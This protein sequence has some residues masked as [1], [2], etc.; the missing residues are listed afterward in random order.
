M[1]KQSQFPTDWSL[2]LKEILSEPLEEKTLRAYGKIIQQFA[3]FLDT[4]YFCI[5]QLNNTTKEDIEQFMNMMINPKKSKS[6]MSKAE[7]TTPSPA[8]QALRLSTLNKFYCIA[9]INGLLDA[10]PVNI[11]NVH[12]RM[13]G[14]CKAPPKYLSKPLTVNELKRIHA[15]VA[16]LYQTA[17]SNA[18]ALIARDTAI[19]YLLEAS[20]IT[21]GELVQLDIEMLDITYNPT[22]FIRT[23]SNPRTITLKPISISQQQLRHIILEWLNQRKSL[24]NTE[25][26]N[27]LW[28]SSN[29]NRYSKSSIQNTCSNVMRKAGI[30]RNN[31]G[32]S[33]FRSAY[34]SWHISTG[35][36]YKE[37]AHDLG[38]SPNS[39]QFEESPGHIAR[40]RI[41]RM[42][43]RK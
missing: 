33:L 40:E 39:L 11:Y 36:S 37:I 43:I 9:E 22:L 1:L 28:I 21:I 42:H 10:N 4:K 7:S 31:L 8:T 30:M 24:L 17:K 13:E 27:A 26:T 25:E 5:P 12:R 29:G 15:S 19:L 2:C 23:G 41:R 34:S 14:K 3:T 20:G 6:S 38:V 18:S 35:K 16:L 32:A